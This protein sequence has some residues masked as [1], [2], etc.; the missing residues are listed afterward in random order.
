[1][2]PGRGPGSY[3]CDWR[4]RRDRQEADG[5]K[6]PC[7]SLGSTVAMPI[8]RSST[9]GIRH[10]RVTARWTVTTMGRLPCWSLASIQ[11]VGM[12]RAK[13]IE[14]S[15]AAWEAAALPLSYARSDRD[16]RQLHRGR[17]IAGAK[18]PVAQWLQPFE[19]SRRCENSVAVALRDLKHSS[20]RI[21][22]QA[23]IS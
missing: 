7:G 2:Q 3:R 19:W 12:E 10:G 1:M 6:P 21:S 20:L 9:R 22:V 17:Q 13:G 5:G 16:S 4:Q 14:P 11:A 23:T 8:T 15:S 18:L